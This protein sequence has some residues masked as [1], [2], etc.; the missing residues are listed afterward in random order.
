M[1]SNKHL[2]MLRAL[3][4]FIISASAGIIEAVV[5]ALFNELTSWPYWPSYL[6]ALTASVVWN[7]TLNRR[8]TFRST[9]N[10][11]RAMLL[12]AAFYAVFTPVTTILGNYLAETLGWNEYLVTALN[13]ACNLVT[14]YLYDTYVVFRDS[15]D[16]NTVAKRAAERK[17]V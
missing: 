16:T 10:V 11:P 15:I 12:V 1:Q 17:T 8:Y 9:A 3:K 6:I 4:F 14:E 5:F 13:M 7:F 2:E